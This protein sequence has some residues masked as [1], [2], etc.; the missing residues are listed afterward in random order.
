MD[1]VKTRM[2]GRV[3]F[4]DHARVL[5]GGPVKGWPPFIFAA[6]APFFAA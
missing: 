5:G 6:I 1:S 4:F 3:K 2:H